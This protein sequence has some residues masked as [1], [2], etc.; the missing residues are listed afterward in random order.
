[1]TDS[2]PCPCGSTALFSECCEP[3]IDGS[4]VP[5]TA[6]ELLRSRYSAYCTKAIDYIIDTHDPK[7]REELDRESITSWAQESEWLGL[8]ILGCD[9]GQF[10]DTSGRI[11]FSARYRQ[12]N[13][14]IDHL[15][16][17]F[18][19][20]SGDRW[21]FVDGH[22]PPARRTEPKIGRNAP[23]PCASGKK[24]KRC[25]GQAKAAAN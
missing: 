4:K 6:I 5:Q 3:Y 15:E 18:F 25:C 14:K 11:R 10:D 13:Q 12:N 9:G 21:Y 19:E 22:T 8:E 17:A 2:K 1:M 16:E 7:T 23:C 20:R 24:Y